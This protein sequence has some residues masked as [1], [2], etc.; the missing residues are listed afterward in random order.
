[1]LDNQ[2]KEQIASAL[3]LEKFY[4]SKIDNNVLKIINSDKNSNIAMGERMSKY[5]DWLIKR[6][7]SHNPSYKKRYKMLKK[8]CKNLSPHQAYIYISKFIGLDA[9]LGYEG[10]KKDEKLE[11][12]RDNEVK[13]EVQVGRHFIVG[14]A[15]GENG[16][17]Y[18]IECMFFYA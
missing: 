1:M 11:F 6:P 18:G 5:L 10:M 12:I 17:E 4:E 13:P 7:Q 3:W 8:Y 15:W 2:T 9:T 16:K 14:S